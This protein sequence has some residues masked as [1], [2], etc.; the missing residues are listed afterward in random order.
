MRTLKTLVWLLI[1]ACAL[2]ALAQDSLNVTRI[3]QQ[4]QWQSAYAVAVQGDYAYIAAGEGGLRIVDISDSTQLVEVGCYDT[5]GSATS[6]TVGGS[7]AY[8]GDDTYG[9]RI[10]DITNPGTPTEAGFYA[11][12]NYVE[13]VAISG[14]YAYVADDYAACRSSTSRIPPPRCWWALRHP[15]L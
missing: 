8:V 15:R 2:P 11:T 7:Y 14:N 3:W 6:V 9:L 13:G 5:P 4:S 1:F 12:I 10:I